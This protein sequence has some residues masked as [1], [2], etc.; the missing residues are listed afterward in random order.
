MREIKVI[1]LGLV[2]FALFLLGFPFAV[3]AAGFRMLDAGMQMVSQFFRA[4]ATKISKR[5]NE[6]LEAA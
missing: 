6:L 5:I 2:F 3:L 4:P 1:G